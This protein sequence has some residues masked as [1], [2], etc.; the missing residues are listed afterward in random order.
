MSDLKMGPQLQKPQIVNVTDRALAKIRRLLEANKDAF[1]IRVSV[2]SGGCSGLSYAIEY[3]SSFGI[4]DEKL[5][6]E[7]VTILIDKKAVLYILGSTMD[8]VE[9][10]FKSGFIFFNPKERVKCGCGKSFSV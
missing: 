2:R 6:I 5:L 3:A 10:Q 7:D 9:E 1:A 4:F 8:Y